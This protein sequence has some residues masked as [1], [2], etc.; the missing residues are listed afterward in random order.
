MVVLMASSVVRQSRIRALGGA[1]LVSRSTSTVEADIEVRTLRVRIDGASSLT[2][3][4]E[5]ENL[6]ANVEG[7]SGI[8]AFE[9]EVKNGDLKVSGASNARVNVTENLEATTSGFGKIR[10]K[11]E[12]NDV[13]V[14]GSGSG[15]SKED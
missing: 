7:A 2:L 4:G 12:P 15:I 6:I 11:G 5:G 14:H 3:N 13:N 1:A 10:Y 9:Y 8:D